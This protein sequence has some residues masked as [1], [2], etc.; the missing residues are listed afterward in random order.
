MIETGYALSPRQRQHWRRRN[1]W[2]V[3]V[4]QVSIALEAQPQ[5]GVE[6]VASALAEVIAR[7]EALRTSLQSLDGMAYPVQ[8][9]NVTD[10]LVEVASELDLDA[11]AAAQRAAVDAAAGRPF[12][13]CVAAGGTVLLLTADRLAADLRSLELVAGEVASLLGGATIVENPPLQHLDFAAWHEDV[14]LSDEAEADRSFWRRALGAPTPIEGGGPST[15][16]QATLPVG[17]TEAVALAHRAGVRSDDAVATT[18][19]LAAAWATILARLSGGTA[20]VLDVADDARSTELLTAAIGPIAVDLPVPV[21][22]AGASFVDVVDRLALAVAD[23]AERTDHFEHAVEEASDVML[24]PRLDLRAAAPD[25]LSVEVAGDGDPRTEL[26][27]QRRGDALDA[28]VRTTSAGADAAALLDYLSHVLATAV[29]EPEREALRLPVA[30]P[31]GPQPIVGAEPAADPRWLHELVAEH[32]ARTPDAPAVRTADEAIGYG[33]LSDRVGRLASALR[34][35]GVQDGNLVPIVADRTVDLV[36]AALAVNAT[37]AGFVPIDETNPPER[38]RLILEDV[39]AQGRGDVVL[40]AGATSTALV[41]E[42]GWRPLDVDDLLTSTGTDPAPAPHS[43]E[44]RAA[45]DVAYVM[46]TSGTTGVPNGVV[47]SHGAWANYLGWAADRYGAHEGGVVHSSI[48]FDLTITSLFAPLAA[49]GEV[50]LLP[51]QQSLLALAH[52]VGEPMR[53]GVLKMTPTHAKVLHQLLPPGPTVADVSTIV[54]GGE[55]LAPEVCDALWSHFLGATIVNEYGP[56]ETVVG[57]TWSV[58]DGRS[59]PFGRIPIGRPIAGTS[60]QVLDPHGAAVPVGVAGEL[61]IG[62]VG[63]TEGYLGRPD[64][65]ESR[66]VADPSSPGRRMYRTGDIVRVRGDGELEYLGRADQQIKVRGV[67]IDPAEIERVLTSRPDVAEAVVVAVSSDRPVVLREVTELVA[68][69]V[70]RDTADLE[71]ISN[72]SVVSALRSTCRDHLPDAMVPT[73]FVLLASLPV[74]VNGKLDRGALPRPTRQSVLRVTEFVEPRTTSEDVLASAVAGTL[75]IAEVGIDDDYFLLGGDS[76][77]SVMIVSQA[78]AR[79]LNVTAADLHELRTV[80]ACAAAADGRDGLPRFTPTEPFSLIDDADRALVPPDVEDAF[81]LNLLQEGMIFH[82]AFAAKSAVYHAIASVRLRAPFDLDILRV[83]VNQLVNRHPMLRTSFDQTTFSKPL[84]LVHRT[85]EDPLSFQDLRALE[86]D[87]RDRYIDAWITSEKARGFELDEFPLIRFMAQR[88][89]DDQW[90]FTYG[91]HHEIVDG[92]SEALMMTELFTHYL[93]MVYGEPVELREPTSSMRDAVALEIE[94]LSRPENYEFWDR[95]LADAT[96]MRL[97]RLTTNL[98]A[99]DGSRD[100]KRLEVP[101]SKPVSDGLRALA[102]SASLPLKDVL[103][104]AHMFVMSRYGGNLDTLTYTVTQ[105]RPETGDGT[106]AIGLFVNSLA[107]RVQM[108]GGTWRDLASDILDS[109]VSSMPYRRLPMAELKRHQG[110]EPLAETLFFFTD[111]HVFKILDRWRDRGVEAVDAE[112]Y[113]ESTFPFC[114][115]FRTNRDTDDLEVRLEYDALQFSTPLMEGICESYVAALEAMVAAPERPYVDLDL[116]PAAD[117]QVVSGLAAPRSIAGD[118]LSFV[119]DQLAAV[120]AA[121]PDRVALRLAD[122]EVTY[123]ALLARADAGAAG[124]QQ[125]EVGPEQVVAVVADRSVDTIVAIL[126]VLR[127]GAA[128]LPL[129]PALPPERVAAMLDAAGARHVVGRRSHRSSTTTIADLCAAEGSRL[130]HR[131]HPDTSCYTIFTS[132]STGTPKGVVVTHR[133]L[134]TSTAARTAFY[135]DE[136][137]SAFLL[138]SPL[139]FDSSV[140]GLFWT[141][142]TG[143][144]LVLPDEGQLDAMELASTVGRADVT[145]LLGIPSLYGAILDAA[146]GDDLASLEIVISAGEAC[147]TELFEHHSARLPHA[148]FVNEYGPTEATVWCTAWRGAPGIRA[149]VPIGRPI[150]NAGIAILNAHGRST[151]IGVVGELE[152]N[153]EGVARGYAGQ[154]ALTAERFVPTR[155]GPLGGRAYATGDLARIGPADEIEFFGRSDNQVK[156]RGFRVEPAEVECALDEHPLVQRATVVAR[157]NDAGD[158]ELVANVV[159]VAGATPEPTELQRHLRGLL[160]RY[161]VPSRWR[162]VEA[163]PLTATGK[164]DRR[165]LTDRAAGAV[166]RV[167][168]VV[169]A[170]TPTESLLADLWREVLEVG[171]VGVHDDFFDL[172]GESLRAMQLLTKVNKLVGLRLSVKDMFDATTIEVQAERIDERLARREPDTDLVVGTL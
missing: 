131:L 98:K 75:G 164:V 17:W 53:I 138:L 65:T 147:P 141:L 35:E 19:V 159:P 52:L 105:G 162:I 127:A 171:E 78:Q 132:G 125:L 126:A 29:H 34:A 165:E 129:D 48:G 51:G 96:L 169:D 151:P 84:Q 90:Q 67:R 168:P 55:D 123:G 102:R 140:A 99:D 161:M 122:S 172:G 16:A 92:W 76:I 118:E 49:G 106:S 57:S 87:E 97:P 139:S 5:A 158:G 11:A 121:T 46:Y 163:L 6:Q 120:A 63:V 15:V 167:V 36:T 142:T 145:H 59:R 14:L 124:L 58:V 20:V 144:T 115:I 134:T 31:S 111:Y 150:D 1:R 109:E 72:A 69:V 3:Q 33:E 89:D 50:T 38:I 82:R 136:P 74:T 91:F 77:R 47:V 156:I 42:G 12:G 2:G 30:R 117:R 103:L 28:R 37:G 81:P 44:R 146:E 26:V 73:S 100:I 170:R 116:L 114:A 154:A 101:M 80:R 13:A 8:S 152:V 86:R 107:L 133:G 7:H 21:H 83:A 18:A 113:G 66:F 61:F 54:V 62:G 68:Y 4:V 39:L 135:R 108:S 71:G 41:P 85:F 153:G 40:A 155:S 24:R 25:E 10:A 95:Y 45:T 23:A 148:A 110:N 130:A 119:P 128:Y 9:V 94:A 143:G 149:Q 166:E 43:P 32:G 104:A 79:G 112:L 56:T 70:P 88:L 60:L 157:L 22:L 160:P 64:E 93:S 137:P 27:V